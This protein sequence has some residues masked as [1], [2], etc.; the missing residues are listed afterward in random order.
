MWKINPDAWATENCNTQPKQNEREQLKIAIENY[1][2][3]GE[4]IKRVPILR[5]SQIL[6]SKRIKDMAKRHY[7]TAPKR[8]P[9]RECPNCKTV[10]TH[11]EWAESIF[12]ACPVCEKAA[13][14]D[15]KK[16]SNEKKTR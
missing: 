14:F 9:S 16:V 2:K 3:R 4:K 8:K 15:F 1:L 5:R 12:A 11:T 7:S 13:L 6:N 10:L